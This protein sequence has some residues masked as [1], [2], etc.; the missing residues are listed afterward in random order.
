MDIE[1]EDGDRATV[2]ILYWSPRSTSLATR[3]REAAH[4]R[5][6]AKLKAINWVRSM[7]SSY[8]FLIF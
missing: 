6:V 3:E 7:S 5:E 4:D 8:L 1:E 2:Q